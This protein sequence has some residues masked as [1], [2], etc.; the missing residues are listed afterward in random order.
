MKHKIIIVAV[1]I[2][3]FAGCDSNG[4]HCPQILT[5]PC[6]SVN[7]PDTIC[8]QSLFVVKME[9]FDYGGYTDAQ[10]VAEM[11]NDTIYITTWVTRDECGN[12]SSTVTDVSY[13]TTL[14]AYGTYY[15]TYLLANATGDSVR[16]MIDSVKVVMCR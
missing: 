11:V 13:H 1:V 14:S 15:Y 12:S 4:E 7:A 3:L 6:A 16:F 9:L 5:I 2:A 10:A 8:A